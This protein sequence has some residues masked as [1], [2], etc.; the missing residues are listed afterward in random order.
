MPASM[1]QT[2]MFDNFILSRLKYTHQSVR[3]RLS[4]EKGNILVYVVI[5]MVIFGLLGAL[6]VS[7]F[8]TSIG[9]SATANE[10]RRALYFYES[11][12]RYAAS[13]LINNLPDFSS[14]TVNRLNS[15]TYKID[16][17][18]S[19]KLKVFGLNFQS[20]S[21]LNPATNLNLK[22][23]KGLLP[24]SFSIPT[25][26]PHIFVVNF[27][28]PR[29]AN[30]LPD[31]ESA[32]TG[33]TY[34]DATHVSLS[35]ADDFVVGEKKPV[36]FAVRPFQDDS[37]NQGGALLVT[38]NAVSLFPRKNGVIV[39]NGK[40]YFYDNRIDSENPNYAKLTN[41][42]SDSK[43]QNPF[44]MVITASST[45]VILSPEIHIITAEGKS[46]DV[47]YT[48]E[49]NNQY[50]GS[51]Y[52]RQ[53]AL[54]LSPK[55][56]NAD[57]DF[58][59]EDNL[60]IAVGGPNAPSNPSFIT[61]DNFDKSIVV[62]GGSGLGAVW[63]RDTR[64]IGGIRDYCLNGECLFETGIRVFFTLEY[65]GSGDGLIFAL[66]NGGLN[67]L[68][69]V[70][71]DFEA[72]ELLGYAGDSR[73][74]NSG[75][76]LDTS[77]IKGLRPPKMG[78]EFDT[79]RN[80]DQA[81]ETKPVNFCSGSS[82]RQ[83]TRNDP[84]PSSSAKDYV[85][86]V[87]WG[88]NSLTAPCRGTNAYLYDDNRHDPAGTA[89]E[90]WP[91]TL[92]GVVNTS[93]AISSDGKTIYVGSNNTD[94]NPATGWLYA[95]DLDSDGYPKTGS[96]TPFF[97]WSNGVTSP[98]LGS[99]GTIYIGSGHALYAFTPSKSPKSG[100]PVNLPFGNRTTKPVIASDGTIYIA[101]NDGVKFGYLYAIKPDG[102][103][104]ASWGAQPKTIQFFF[105][106]PVLSR[107]ESLVYAAAIP[108]NVY[109][110]KTSDGTPD[111]SWGITGKSPGGN[112]NTAPA[113]GPSGT[114]TKGT[115]YV[116]TS[117]K[118]VYA[119]N[120]NDGSTLWTSI[121]L[122]ALE[123]YSS[124]PVV[125]P[126]G[127]VYIGNYDDHLYA[128]IQNPSNPA[129]GILLWKYYA[130][131][132]VQ[133]T[134]FIDS[135]NTIYFGSDIRDPSIDSRNVYALYSDGTEKWRFQTSSDV[136][137]TPAVKPD[138][139]VYVGSNNFNF[140]AINQFA[141]PKS[142]K[143]KYISYDGTAVGSVPVTIDAGNSDDWLRGSASKGPW[144]V[145]MEVY[146]SLDPNTTAPVGFYRYEL[147]SWVR[148]CEQADC[149]DVLGTFFDDTR[150]SYSPILRPPQMEQT[151][152]LSG[153]SF[154]IN[155]DH[156]N[157]Y[158]FLFGFTSQTASSD[159]Q[160]ST[161]RQLKLSFVR[162]TDATIICDPTWPDGTTCP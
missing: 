79:K 106:Y 31:Q 136:R 100:F 132:N 72:P 45:N 93:P 21:E 138:G 42:Q 141:T 7:L 134:P 123:S 11:G 2:P 44:P 23:D 143:N 145:R 133:S 74:N 85:Q 32:I 105:T 33:F 142:L 41:I 127:T 109:A 64:P 75:S 96:E 40:P 12:V 124:S 160:T 116:G 157:F 28:D 117:D 89:T 158:Q 51:V 98:V 1:E 152:F 99:D 70:G 57:I 62:S 17:A 65:S 59:K 61:V 150:V 156:D 71:G 153:S 80:W 101:S 73:L 20:I 83:N 46:G 95:I 14:T 137:G 25:T 19:F 121:G 102:S 131:G 140:Y 135:S 115:V 104:K 118:N 67:Q 78:L 110:L 68:A 148:Q 103:F 39:V 48:E 36:A 34:Q 126:N 63:F 97:S 38:R 24:S 47:T 149:T 56:H 86:Y 60:N 81:F 27:E 92:S 58:G 84:D 43:I 159:S 122:A 112:I 50:G 119:L 6:M 30:F 113:V 144:A 18:G 37:I 9:S 22:L 147:R 52:N 107:D 130:V 90:D 10:S 15:N 16:P 161:I 8:S 139:V 87:Y 66:L 3:A 29:L 13:E 49:W 35:L 151:I 125:G 5:V 128:I 155:G 154:G 162:Q 53:D 111:L 54:G 108:G 76:F 26:A 88:A 114:T 94:I 77:G 69:S 4:G 120:G 55:S 129:Q 91:L 146:R 82:L